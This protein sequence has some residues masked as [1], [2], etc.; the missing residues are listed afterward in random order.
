MAN[1]R[2]LIDYLPPYMQEYLEIKEILKAEQPEIDALWSSVETAFA[3]QYIM[4]ATEYGVKRWETMLHIS[5]K[6]TET[7]DERKFR[8]LT[9][10]NQKLPYT[11]VRLREALTTLCGDNG[12]AIDLQAN[13][14]SITI[15]LG[16]GN[17]NNYQ[18]VNDMLYNMIPANM[19]R[20]ITLMY[21]THQMVGLCRH[22][23]LAAFTHKEVRSEVLN[24]A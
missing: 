24:N 5:P 6:A 22:K 15:K 3:N 9:R 19:T 1:N 21:N 14:Y 7:L 13:Q 23:D 10:L 18:A 8:I 12:F 2:F 20:Y 4:D 16:V 11:L 17:H